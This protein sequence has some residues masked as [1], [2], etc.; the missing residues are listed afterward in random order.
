MLEFLAT[1]PAQA[2]LSVAT[3]IALMV[4]GYYLV[5]RFGGRAGD[6]EQVSSELLTNFREMH[7]QGDISDDEYRNIKTVLGAELQGQLKDTGEEA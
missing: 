4:F 3:L 2:V 7:H 1:P 5:R 6:D